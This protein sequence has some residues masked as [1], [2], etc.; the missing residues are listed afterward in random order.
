MKDIE[1]ASDRALKGIESILPPVVENFIA[2]WIAAHRFDL[3]YDEQDAQGIIL[4]VE[5]TV[6]TLPKP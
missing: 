3:V 5:H 4:G 1:K 6:C 2:V